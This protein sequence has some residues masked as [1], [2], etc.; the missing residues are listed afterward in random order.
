ML[1]TLLYMSITEQVDF[2][3]QQATTTNQ[4]GLQLH[5]KYKL[6]KVPC[7]PGSHFS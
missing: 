2:K 7:I 5:V 1:E 4:N 6:D 3:H